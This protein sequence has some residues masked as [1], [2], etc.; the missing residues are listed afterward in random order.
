MRTLVVP[1]FG[2]WKI[3]SLTKFDGSRVPG[4]ECARL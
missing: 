3:E 4:M 2:F 1:G